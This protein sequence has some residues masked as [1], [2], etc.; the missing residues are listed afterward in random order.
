MAGRPASSSPSFIGPSW[1]VPGASSA[2]DGVRPSHHVGAADPRKEPI[3][4]VRPA[5]RIGLGGLLR[6]AAA[7]AVVA[8]TATAVSGGVRRHQ[9]NNAQQAAEAQA[10]EQQQYAPQ[11]QFAPPPQQYAPQP[12]YAPTRKTPHRRR[13]PTPT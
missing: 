12:Q 5:R 2:A 7:T 4:F 8:G 3:T 1:R 11:P 9:Y 13:R 10:Y 6:T